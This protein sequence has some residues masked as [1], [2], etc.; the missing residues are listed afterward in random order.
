MV[1]LP[2]WSV[3]AFPQP[4]LGTAAPASAI[5]S[6]VAGAVGLAPPE[7]G[8]S[9]GGARSVTCGTSEFDGVASVVDPPCAP[10]PDVP[11]AAFGAFCSGA[12]DSADGDELGAPSS[13]EQAAT[14]RA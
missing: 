5:S 9:S 1:W 12:G 11:A 8:S 13:P 7:P 14:P 4:A 10:S 3:R 2:S 6:P